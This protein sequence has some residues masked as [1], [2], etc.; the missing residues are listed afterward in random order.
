MS[1]LALA[2]V[3]LTLQGTPDRYSLTTES[4]SLSNLTTST[5]TPSAY[6]STW[7]LI[8]IVGYRE[9]CLLL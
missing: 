7:N 5:T 3:V 1:L 8:H 9:N 4:Y 6:K 2:I